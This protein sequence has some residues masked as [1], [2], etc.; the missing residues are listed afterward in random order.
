MGGVAC[1][2]SSVAGLKTRATL[3]YNATAVALLQTATATL[4][5]Y[6]QA[7]PLSEV[8][9]RILVIDLATPPPISIVDFFSPARKFKCAETRSAASPLDAALLS[10]NCCGRIEAKRTLATHIRTL[11]GHRK[12]FST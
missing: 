7:G 5:R 8:L 1:R 9:L 12:T 2:C 10:L 3:R 6:S 11:Y 4:Q